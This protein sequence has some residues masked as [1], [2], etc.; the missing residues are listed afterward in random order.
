MKLNLTNLILNKP[1]IKE[2]DISFENENLSSFMLKKINN[3]HVKIEATLYQDL[4]RIKFDIYAL[5]TGIC[6]YTLEDVP[7]PVKIHDELS[8]TNDEKDTSS[9]LIEENII[10]IDYY[11]LSLILS[12]IPKKII[13]EG[14]KLPPSGDGYRVLKE[15]DLEE[16]REKNKTSPFDVLDNLEL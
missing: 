12:Y 2:E 7:L 16:E 8:F 3:C 6:A 11:T 13:K 15:E 10:D 5:A 1:I 4:L 14:A 9:I